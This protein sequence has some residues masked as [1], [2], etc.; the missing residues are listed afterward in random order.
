MPV[1]DRLHEIPDAAVA[2]VFASYPPLVRERLLDLRALIL[3]TAA[4]TEGVGPVEE[5]LRWGE[6]AFL[7]PSGSGTT[8]RIAP[9]RGAAD[10]YGLFVPCQ[11]PLIGDVRPRLPDGVEVDGTRGLLFHVADALPTAVLAQ[12]IARALC[13]KADQRSA[14]RR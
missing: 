10:H 11:T 5:A 4:E 7:T 2:A 6:P 12:V 8:I 9:V 13:Y 1:S 14:K 3:T